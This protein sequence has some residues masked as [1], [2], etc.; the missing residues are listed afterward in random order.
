MSSTSQ[1]P[2]VWAKTQ[3]WSWWSTTAPIR[4]VWSTVWSGWTKWR[5][6]ITKA[7]WVE[8]LWLLKANIKMQ[9]KLQLKKEWAMPKSWD[10]SS[11]RCQPPITPMS[12]NPSKNLQVKHSPFPVPASHDIHQPLSYAS[13]TLILSAITS[14]FFF[15]SSRNCWDFWICL[16]KIEK[17]KYCWIQCKDE[18]SPWNHSSFFGAPPF[19]V[20]L[21]SSKYCATNYTGF[22]GLHDGNSTAPWPPRSWPG[23]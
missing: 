21:W 20:S 12:K 13:S 16:N 9:R 18:Y 23:A 5:N 6:W 8:S 10:S 11:F 4:I 22:S 15:I 19:C 14:V 17:H 1:W 3:I 7:T 2:W